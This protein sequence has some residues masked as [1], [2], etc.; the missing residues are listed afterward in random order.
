MVNE[1]ESDFSKFLKTIEEG[2]DGNELLE[3]LSQPNKPRKSRSPDSKLIR[4]QILL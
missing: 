3:E 4:Y 2:F 1:S